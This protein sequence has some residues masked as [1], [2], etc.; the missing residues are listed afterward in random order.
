MA[1]EEKKAAKKPA[2]EVVG[3]ILKVILGMVLVVLGIW[4]I[5]LWRVDVLTIIK[6]AVGV[7]FLL[8]GIICFAIAKE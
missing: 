6:G 8:A 7:V 4:G 5:Y 1:E 3:K 2:K